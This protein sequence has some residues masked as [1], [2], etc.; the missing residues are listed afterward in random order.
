MGEFSSL[1]S[2]EV[3]CKITKQSPCGDIKELVLGLKS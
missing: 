3:L 1:I 2:E